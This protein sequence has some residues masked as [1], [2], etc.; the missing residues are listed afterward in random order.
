MYVHTTEAA[1]LLEISS[2]RLLQLLQ[3]GRVIGA[4]KSGH[5]WMIPLHDGLPQI[6][7]GKR[8]KPGTW[9]TN[10]V[11]KKIIIHINGNNIKQNA[12]RTPEERK[13]VITIKSNSACNISV[14]ES[15][16]KAKNTYARALEIPYPGRT[17]YQPDKPLDCGVSILY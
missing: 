16:K 13:P 1:N 8:G 17:V 9:K 3:K 7:K 4:Y 2:R 10:R 11:Q 15:Q 14:G 5:C 6:I 12:K